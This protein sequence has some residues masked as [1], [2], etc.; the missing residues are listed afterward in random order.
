MFFI[1]KLRKIMFG[2]LLDEYIIQEFRVKK[3]CVLCIITL[4]STHS[5]GMHSLDL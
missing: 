3:I 4:G 1:L 5:I 2:E